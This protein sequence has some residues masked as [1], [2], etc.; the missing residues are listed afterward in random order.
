MGASNAPSDEGVGFVCEGG[1]EEEEAELKRPMLTMREG[2]CW[3]TKVRVWTIEW[4]QC[5]DFSLTWTDQSY[6]GNSKS[7]DRYST[8]GSGEA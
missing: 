4:F 3:W 7:A 2:I 8:L 6:R 5:C 1:G